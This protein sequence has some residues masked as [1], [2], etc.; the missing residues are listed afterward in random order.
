[1]INKLRDDKQY[2]DFN[3]SSEENGSK[4]NQGLIFWKEGCGARSFTSDNYLV[5]TSV[6]KTLELPLV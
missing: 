3:I 6:Y 4:L 1:V 5:D 2:F